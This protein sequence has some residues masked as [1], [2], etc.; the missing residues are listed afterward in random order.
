MSDW[1]PSDVHIVVNANREVALVDNER[2][3]LVGPVSLSDAIG[4]S[5][6]TEWLFGYLTDTTPPPRRND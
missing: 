1:S 2:N 4:V 5:V 6:L 3:L